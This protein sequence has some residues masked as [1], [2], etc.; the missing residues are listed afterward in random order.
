[1]EA[2]EMIH[3]N[4]LIQLDTIENV[5]EDQYDPIVGQSNVD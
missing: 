4:D 5:V 2:V 3:E 1:M